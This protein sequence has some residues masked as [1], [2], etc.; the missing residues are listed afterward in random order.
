MS[1]TNDYTDLTD[2]NGIGAAKAEA[3]RDA[4]FDTIDDIR[5][6]AQEDLTA[7]NGISDALAARIKDDVGD[8]PDDTT[9]SEPESEPDDSSPAD[10]ATAEPAAAG[11]TDETSAADGDAATTEAGDEEQ[12]PDTQ[13][14][15][16]ADTDQ[17]ADEED[18]TATGGKAERTAD[19]VDAE[20][21][22]E[23]SGVGESKADAL[24]AA[25]IETVADVQERSQ[26]ELADVE[27]IG[28]ALAARM[29]ADVGGLEVAEETEADVE[30]EEPEDAAAAEV[31]MELQPRG[32]VEKTPD[33]SAEEER[34][35]TQRRSEQKPQ[36]N[37][38]DYHKK[39]RTP[40]SWRKPRG[41]LSKQ[42][43][44]IKGKGST[45]EA[46][47][48]TPTTVRGKH[49]SGFEEVR[50]ENVADLEGV[51][52]DTEAVRIGSTV[53]GRKRERIEEVAEDEGIR[54]LN[55]TYVEVEVEV[56]GSDD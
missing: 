43:R 24:R 45:V 30:E 3:L 23:I 36:F 9:E 35:L 21:L 19:A 46:G 56:D 25:G 18:A 13:P 8:V 55:P 33:L 37:R 27:G 5:E 40:S 2:I 10:D 17:P 41:G 1:D 53:G 6:A 14:T 38:Q 16:A 12:S 47:F 15:D 11:D 34:L 31:E 39:K 51:D 50:V 52:G 32:L 7:T 44:G 26:E 42:R 48:R 4:G 29:K 54:V 22:T 28:N 49:P 20:G